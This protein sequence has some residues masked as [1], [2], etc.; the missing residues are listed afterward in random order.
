MPFSIPSVNA[1]MGC[2]CALMLKYNI[3]SHTI[4]DTDALIPDHLAKKREREREE[5]EEEAHVTLLLHRDR[6]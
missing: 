5:E 6:N 4:P 3:I 1:L 2:F